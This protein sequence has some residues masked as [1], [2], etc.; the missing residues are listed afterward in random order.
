MCAVFTTLQ[1]AGRKQSEKIEQQSF[2]RCSRKLPE[3]LLLHPECDA[4]G[5]RAAQADVTFCHDR[6]SLSTSSMSV[7]VSHKEQEV[8]MKL[9]FSCFPPFEL[10]FERIL[11]LEQF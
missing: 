7:A 9:C 6:N 3:H 11:F 8:T 4:V 10:I 5:T 2:L 1:C